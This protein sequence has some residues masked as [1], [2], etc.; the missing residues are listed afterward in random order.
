MTTE[1]RH[2]EKHALIFKNRSEYWSSLVKKFIHENQHVSAFFPFVFFLILISKKNMHM[3]EN[4]FCDMLSFFPL[5]LFVFVWQ[6]VCRDYSRANQKV[7]SGCFFRACL[8][9]RD[10]KNKP[11]THK[12]TFIPMC[13]YIRTLI[14]ILYEN[15][16]RPVAND[17]F[18]AQQNICFDF[19]IC[20]RR[21]F[22]DYV[23]SC[24]QTAAAK[25]I[26]TTQSYMRH[27][28]SVWEL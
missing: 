18:S 27:R 24:T 23:S 22:A 5:P 10:F 28:Q 4:P 20:Q 13:V 9:M 2:E 3:T 12:H 14:Y 25:N 6:H 21:S 16:I 8:E 11:S 15:K 7:A 19:F 26:S 17:K 1:N